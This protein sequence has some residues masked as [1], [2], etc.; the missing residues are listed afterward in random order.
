MKKFYQIK[1]YP[2]K[3]LVVEVCKDF[4]TREVAKSYLEDFKKTA[5]Q[6]NGQK[7]ALLT[8]ASLW[9]SDSDEA[10][11]EIIGDHFD[12]NRQNGMAH[13]ANIAGGLI[14]QAKLKKMFEAGGVSDIAKVFLDK[15]DAYRWLKN[16]G[17]NL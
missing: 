11:I 14:E 9:K 2:E 17:Y 3:R 4:W 7:W 15:K 8:D 13:N 16:E 6:L 12:W 5:S 10:V 1:A